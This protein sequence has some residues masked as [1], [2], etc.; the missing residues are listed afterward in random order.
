MFREM[1]FVLFVPVELG[2]E[3][4]SFWNTK[5]NPTNNAGLPSVRLARAAY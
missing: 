2:P 1:P 5:W 4:T 3:I